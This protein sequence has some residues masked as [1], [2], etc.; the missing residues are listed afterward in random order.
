[1]DTAGREFEVMV[2]S[3]AGEL[4]RYAHGLCRDVQIAEDLVQET[5]L[6]A[7]KHLHT[8]T[9]RHTLRGW[10]YAILRNEHS[11]LCLKNQ[12]EPADLDEFKLAAPTEYDTSTEA[13][14]LRRAVQSLPVAYQEPLLLQV[15]AGFSCRE[16]AGIL[17]LTPGNVMTRVS[18]ARR[19]LR[20]S[21]QKGAE[22]VMNREQAP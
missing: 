10:L 13:Y 18:R 9:N 21:L 15:L 17:N 6:R 2:R 20:D 1:M 5:F 12:P 8:Q 4:Y 16:I 22:C 19:K 14:V 3:H 7:W 11:R